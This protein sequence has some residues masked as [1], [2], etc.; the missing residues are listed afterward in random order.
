[1]V[2]RATLAGAASQWAWPPGHPPEPWRSPARPQGSTSCL[3][4][5]AVSA[6]PGPRSGHTAAVLRRAHL[7]L[8]IQVLQPVVAWLVLPLFAVRR[9]IFVSEPLT[10]DTDVDRSAARQPRR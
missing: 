3:E 6:A 7:V 2:R 10:Q 8:P 9:T 5:A 1:S 4:G